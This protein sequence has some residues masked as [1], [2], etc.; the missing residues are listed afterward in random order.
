[1]GFRGYARNS[2]RDGRRLRTVTVLSLL[3]STSLSAVALAATA[4]ADSDGLNEIVVTGSRR[5]DRS[6][7]K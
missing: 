5:V 2:A 4:P 3:A 1:M 7:A 6:A